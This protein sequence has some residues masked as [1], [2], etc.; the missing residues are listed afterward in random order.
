MGENEKYR[1][2]LWTAPELLRLPEHDRPQSGTKP[3]D[4]YSFAILMQ[5]ILYRAA[6][7]FAEALASKGA[8]QKYT[9]EAYFYH[10]MDSH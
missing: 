8:R 3:G 4:V 6:P 5:E 7:Y 2:L 1:K 10:W 9:N